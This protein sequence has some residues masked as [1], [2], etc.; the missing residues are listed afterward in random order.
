MGVIR[1]LFFWLNH[2]VFAVDRIEGLAFLIKWYSRTEGIQSYEVYSSI[3]RSFLEAYKAH[4]ILTLNDY[5]RLY[6]LLWLSGSLN[7]NFVKKTMNILDDTR[8]L[9]EHLKVYRVRGERLSSLI[10]RERANSYE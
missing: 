3:V 5:K 9:E 6:S 10:S 4:N 8:C 2:R 1:I 7:W